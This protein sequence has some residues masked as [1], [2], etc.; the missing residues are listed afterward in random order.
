MLK[1]HEWLVN[2]LVHIERGV[3]ISHVDRLL[4]DVKLLHPRAEQ[5]KLWIHPSR[6]GIS[7]LCHW[8]LSK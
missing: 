8:L 3:S 7:V 4:R 5:F 1:I 2:S 6:H